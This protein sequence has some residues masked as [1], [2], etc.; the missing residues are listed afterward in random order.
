[1]Q[2]TGTAERAS[3]AANDSDFNVLHHVAKVAAQ[4]NQ[5]VTSITTHGEHPALEHAP[6]AR[7]IGHLGTLRRLSDGAFLSSK[8]ARELNRNIFETIYHAALGGAV[9]RVL[10]RRLWAPSEPGVAAIRSGWV[11][12][13]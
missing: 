8:E 10:T 13:R 12:P 9:V 7:G 5:V 6:P 4:P 3:A 1:V 11:R 2:T